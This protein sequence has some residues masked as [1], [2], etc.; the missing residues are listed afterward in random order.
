MK[1]FLQ[2]SHKYIYLLKE[3]QTNTHL[4]QKKNRRKP[5][6][7][8]PKIDRSGTL[9]FYWQPL[10]HTLMPLLISLFHTQQRMSPAAVFLQV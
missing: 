1:G 2:L 4:P 8:A 5:V 10:F 7:T 6:N 3:N 9:H